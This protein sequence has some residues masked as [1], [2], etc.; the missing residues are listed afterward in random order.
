FA[1]LKR[2]S[3]DYGE[4]AAILN[5]VVHAPLALRWFEDRIGLRMA[6]I[7]DCP[8]YYYG[9]SNDAV[10][11][12]RLLEAEPFDAT[13]LGEWQTR[14]RV[15]PLVPYGM[16]HHDMFG[17]GGAANMAKWDFGLMAERLANDQ[18]CLGAGLIAYFVKGA[19]D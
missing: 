17:M 11:E 14:T 4:D 3:M 13:T 12:G 9:H 18:R 16:T 10:A 19:I 1:Y 15:S 6:V 2:L 5:F 8:D 7:R